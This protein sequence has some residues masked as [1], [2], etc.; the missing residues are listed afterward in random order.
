MTVELNQ[1]SGDFVKMLNNLYTYLKTTSSVYFIGLLLTILSAPEWAVR[2][3][4]AEPGNLNDVL[5]TEPP[6][7][8][9]D[10]AFQEKRFEEAI[11]LYSKH[12]NPGAGHYGAGMCWEMLQKTDKAAQEYRLALE[13]DPDNYR[14]MENLAGILERVGKDIPQAIQL[15]SKA[16]GLDPREEWRQTLP[17]SIKVL[18]SRLRPEDSFAVGCFHKASAKA[19]KGAVSEAEAM[20]TRAIKLNPSMFQAYFG[21]GMIKFDRGDFR[22]AITDFLDTV[23]LSPSFR[24]GYVHVALCRE[25]MGDIEKALDNLKLAEKFDP[26]DPEALYHLGRISEQKQDYELASSAYTR[27]LVLHV[28]HDLKKLISERLAGLPPTRKADP[29]RKAERETPTRLW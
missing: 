1:S 9:A 16:L 20:F 24:S 12:P 8:A 10:K 23:R 17:W 2:S 28:P 19:Q 14:A 7:F 5:N 11:K 4:A 6:G 25:R 29:K 26:K 3:H 22:E 18:Q 13:A 15:Y 27:A 21:R